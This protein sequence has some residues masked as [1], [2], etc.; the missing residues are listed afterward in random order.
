MSM[1]DFSLSM[2]TSF[3]T[4]A[5]TSSPSIRAASQA[6]STS[7]VATTAVPSALATNS[8]TVGSTTQPTA[9]VPDALSNDTVF[10]TTSPTASPTAIDDGAAA[11]KGPATAD[12]GSS[13]DRQRSAMVA[14]L[15]LVAVGSVLGLAFLLLRRRNRT[16]GSVSFESEEDSSV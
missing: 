3:P 10:A 13:N 7:P 11:I 9:L 1:L 15:V 14:T 16:G 2:A 4:K 12:G 5:P 8:P 6:P